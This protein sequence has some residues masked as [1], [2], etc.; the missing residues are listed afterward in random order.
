[1]SLYELVNVLPSTE[2]GTKF[3]LKLK[4]G[5]RYK[6]RSFRIDHFRHGKCECCGPYM[7][8]SF[9]NSS[10]SI[11]LDSHFGLSFLTASSCLP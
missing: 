3:T 9:R 8:L 2:V 4:R 1:M 6:L 7:V 5:K 11:H 10:R